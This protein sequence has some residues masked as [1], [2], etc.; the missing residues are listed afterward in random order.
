[1]ERITKM[2]TAERYN[3]IARLVEEI[4]QD[5]FVVAYLPI[6]DLHC[7]DWQ[8]EEVEELMVKVALETY[9]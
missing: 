4:R 8:Y 3:E 1:M 9:S 7:K 5:G 2:V 6:E